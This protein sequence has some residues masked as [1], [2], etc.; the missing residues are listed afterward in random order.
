MVDRAN[1]VDDLFAGKVMST[2]DFGVAS[3]AASEGATLGKKARTGGRMNGAVNAAAAKEGLVGRVGD[4]IDLEL[5]Y[6]VTNKT[7]A[8]VESF[9]GRNGAIGFEGERRRNFGAVWR[10]RQLAQLVQQGQ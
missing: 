3:V 9:G 1:C 6:I 10:R 5:G 8:V 7:D 4:R 2:S